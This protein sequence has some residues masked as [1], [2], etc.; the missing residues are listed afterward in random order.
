VKET[1]KATTAEAAI[2]AEK[3]AVTAAKAK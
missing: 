3:A 1:T 2:T